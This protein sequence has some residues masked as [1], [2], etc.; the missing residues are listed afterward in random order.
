MKENDIGIIVINAAIGLH[1]QSDPELLE[2]VYKIVL[3]HEL[4]ERDELIGWRS[5]ILNLSASA[6]LRETLLSPRL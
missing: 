4:K 1:L 5:D 2:K 6:P 3:S